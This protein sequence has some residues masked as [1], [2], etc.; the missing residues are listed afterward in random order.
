[1]IVNSNACNMLQPFYVVLN[2]SLV[3]N[4]FSVLDLEALQLCPT[5]LV[6]FVH[7]LFRLNGHLCAFHYSCKPCC[8]HWKQW[9][10]S[11]A[12]ASLLFAANWHYFDTSFDINNAIQLIA[13]PLLGV[14]RWFSFFDILS[15]TTFVGLFPLSTIS[16]ILDITKSVWK[17]SNVSKFVGMARKCDSAVA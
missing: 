4:A 13:E 10:H 8:C 9:Y 11:F 16:I 7:S 1:M 14:F 5:K 6:F 3:K 15:W 2:Q 17:A 12:E